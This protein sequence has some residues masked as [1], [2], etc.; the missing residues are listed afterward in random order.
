[1]LTKTSHQ[2][3]CVHPPFGSKY[4]CSSV[5]DAESGGKVT[6]EGAREEVEK[7]SQELSNAI[8]MIGALAANLNEQKPKFPK[9][10]KPA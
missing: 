10:V 5:H 1:M 6:R 2:N 7:K 4:L 9:L 3:A 8:Y